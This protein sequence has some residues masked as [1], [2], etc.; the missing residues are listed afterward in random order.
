MPMS[1]ERLFQKMKE[2]GLSTYRIRKERIVSETTLTALRQGRPVSTEAL[3]RFCAVLD[4]QPGDIME[5]IP[6]DAVPPSQ[7]DQ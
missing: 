2:S 5:Y 7:N 6:D 3:C 4:C 1:Y